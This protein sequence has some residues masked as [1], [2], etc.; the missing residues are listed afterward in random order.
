MAPDGQGVARVRDE[1]VW[2]LV[3]D[4]WEL[5]LAIGSGPT[6]PEAAAAMTGRAP[7]EVSE[8]IARLAV[9]GVVRA[10]DGGYS[11]VPAFYERREGMASYLRDVVL[12]RLGAGA[13]P[14]VAGLVE[15]GVGD[16]AAVE[17]LIREAEEALLPEVVRL[18]SAPESE[19]SERFSLIFA[20][21]AGDG[22]VRSEGLRGRLLD[23]LRAAAAGRTLDPHG[24]SAYLW[25]A[26][27]RADPTVAM[28]IGER[29]QAFLGGRGAAGSRAGAA[30]FAVLA[31]ARES[32][33]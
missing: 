25:A 1:L 21:A 28:A 16:A 8:A 13:A 3:R 4:E 27:M 26:E 10:D 15:V 29:L 22:V 5:L 20:V 2:E 14:P 9:R 6:S 7:E 12:G 19:A 31:T 30:G 24:K 33:S 17:A 32:G 11:L 18:A 23:L